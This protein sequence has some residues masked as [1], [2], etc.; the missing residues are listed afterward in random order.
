MFNEKRHPNEMRNFVIERFLNHL[1]VN[2]QVSAATQN[3]AL[4]ATLDS[5]ISSVDYLISVLLRFVV[6]SSKAMTY[7]LLI[8]C[9][10]QE[11]RLNTKFK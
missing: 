8:P 1:A 5:R 11:S 4:C 10:S 7:R 9:Q 6:R 3:Q 2:R